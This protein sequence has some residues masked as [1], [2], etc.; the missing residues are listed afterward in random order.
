MGY[1]IECDRSHLWGCPDPQSIDVG[2]CFS[3]F[4]FLGN[5]HLEFGGRELL[6]EKTEVLSVFPEFLLPY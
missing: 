5:Q 6:K 3:L 1:W 2:S 4:C